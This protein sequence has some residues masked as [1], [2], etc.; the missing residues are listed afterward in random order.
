MFSWNDVLWFAILTGAAVKS[1]AVLGAAWLSVFLLRRHSAATRHLVWTAALAAV[2]ALPFLLVSLPVLRV[3]AA[4]SFLPAATGVMFRAS[5]S[6]SSDGGGLRSAVLPG[7]PNS[8]VS[9]AWSPDW[10][11]ALMLLWAAG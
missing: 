3:P 9:V 2:V 4:A 7:A 1:T 8:F 6:A 5:A 10:K 11:M